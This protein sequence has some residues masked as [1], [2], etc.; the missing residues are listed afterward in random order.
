VTSAQSQGVHLRV[1]EGAAVLVTGPADVLELVGEAGENL[2]EV[3]RAPE[4]PRDRLSTRHRRVLEAVPLRQ[5]A[6]L[7]AIAATAGIELLATQ[8]ALRYLAEREFVV[9]ADSG[10]RLGPRAEPHL[11]DP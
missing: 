5:V 3:A 4:Q 7:G 11:P 9:R 8:T 6:G 2:Q 1:I 10:W